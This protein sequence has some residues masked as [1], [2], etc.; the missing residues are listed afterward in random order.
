MLMFKYLLQNLPIRDTYPSIYINN[1]VYVVV[2]YLR[3]DIA[4]DGFS[5]DSI[6][7]DVEL[8]LR[9]GIIKVLTLLEVLREPGSP[10]LY[11]RI[12]SMRKETGLYAY[13]H[14]VEIHYPIR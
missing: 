1:G 13:H 10:Y 4:K 14:L 6:Q 3:P 9:M 11:I 12:T 7:T 5:R 8:K 2:E